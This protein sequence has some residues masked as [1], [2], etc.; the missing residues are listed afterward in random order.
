MVL[1]LILDITPSLSMIVTVEEDTLIPRLIL[2]YLRV[3]KGYKQ[4]L[5]SHAI[6]KNMG[7]NLKRIDNYRF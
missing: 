5:T 2:N 1:D 6:I 7:S 3:A 4:L